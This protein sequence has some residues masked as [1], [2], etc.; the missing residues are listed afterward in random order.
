ME[1]SK[2]EETEENEQWNKL[3]NILM[4]P[5]FSVKDVED[6]LY[7]KTMDERE[8]ILKV[9]QRRIDKVKLCDKK[10]EKL[11]QKELDKQRA[12]NGLPPLYPEK[13]KVIHIKTDEEL[14][15]ELEEVCKG[16]S[17]PNW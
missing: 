9:I 6:V 7:F 4:K 15:K 5:R 1:E 11:L 3:K 14:T 8:E 2:M 12:L 10:V 13:T 17:N 16:L